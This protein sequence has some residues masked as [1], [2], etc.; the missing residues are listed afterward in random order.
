[1][2]KHTTLKHGNDEMPPEFSFKIVK[3]FNTALERQIYEAVHLR[4]LA[5]T[6]GLKIMNSKGEYN[7]CK[8]PRVVIEGTEYENEN[9]EVGED[10]TETQTRKEGKR[11]KNENEWIWADEEVLGEPGNEEEKSLEGPSKLKANKIE[12]YQ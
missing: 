10:E 11:R 4:I 12:K 2:W 8:I 5:E 6:P 9:K 7:R 1:M 3:S